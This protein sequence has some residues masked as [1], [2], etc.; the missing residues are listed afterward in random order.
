MLHSRCKCVY[1]SARC[2]YSFIG[3]TSKAQHSS[4]RIEHHASRTD[5]GHREKARG[6]RGIRGYSAKKNKSRT[7]RIGRVADSQEFTGGLVEY[8]QSLRLPPVIFGTSL[9]LAG[10]RKSKPAN[11]QEEPE[12]CL[13]VWFSSCPLTTPSTPP[14]PLV[15]LRSRV[16]C[17][18]GM[19]RRYPWLRSRFLESS[20]LQ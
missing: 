2:R 19:Q 8:L 11:Q 12:T 15:Y 18:C 10:C 3:R 6:W 7:I 20:A 9:Q 14:A 13:V 1:H 17:M 5:E 16:R 4:S